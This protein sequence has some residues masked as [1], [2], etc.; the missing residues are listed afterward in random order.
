MN[1]Q[2]Y[3]SEDVLK[4]LIDLVS[5]NSENPPGKEEAAALY[6]KNVMEGLGAEVTLDYVEPGRPN[7]I[8][9]MKFGD[10]RRRILLNSHLDVVCSGDNWTK[11]PF[12][13]II[14]DDKLYGR[15]STDAKGSLAAM[16]A[17]IKRI[18]TNSE[19]EYDGEII[20]TAVVGEETGGLGTKSLIK[21]GLMADA[22]IVGEPTNL[23]VITLQK[24]SYR[25][26]ILFYGKSA[27]SSTPHKGINAISYAARFVVEVEKLND[28]LQSKVHPQLGSGCIS[29]TMINGG[30]QISIIPDFCEISID[31]RLLPGETVE[32][33][34]KQLDIILKDTCQGIRYEKIDLSLDKYPVGISETEEIVK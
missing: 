7:V 31:R 5:F 14:Q 17:G 32:E 25:R 8:A 29:S 18:H 10:G 24:G 21:K 33:C 34:D 28:S 2:G 22:A 15:G 20:L 6:V 9:R 27:H 30:K 19:N 1:M 13:P 3:Y 12:E 16:I 23:E 26:K 11:K 4:Y